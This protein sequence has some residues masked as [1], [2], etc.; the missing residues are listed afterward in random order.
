MTTESMVTL[1]REIADFLKSPE[2]SH[3]LTEIVREFG[4]LADDAS[5]KAALL[6]LD[7]EGLIEITSNWEFRGLLPNSH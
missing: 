6:T 4:A 5:I 3:D 1:K 7:S 2:T